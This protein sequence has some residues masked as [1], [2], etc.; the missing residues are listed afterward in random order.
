MTEQVANPTWFRQLRREANWTQEQ[1]AVRLGIAVSTLR[2]WEQGKVEPSMTLE[3][4]E[5]FAIAVNVPLSEL[6]LRISR[7]A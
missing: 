4:W 5:E 3:Q 7:I 2:T 6:R 1:L